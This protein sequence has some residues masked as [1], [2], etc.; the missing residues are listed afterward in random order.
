VVQADARQLPEL[1]GERGIDQ[2]DVIVS[3]LPGWVD[4]ATQEALIDSV[5]P[6]MGADGVFV[7][8]GYRVTSWMPPAR[9]FRQLL[10]G[11]FDEVVIGRTIRRNI[12][13]AFVRRARKIPV[14]RPGPSDP[15]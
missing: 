8:F 12:P 10:R 7:T 9:R 11:V 1:F 6:V 3:G 14:F 15:G 5:C 2:V 4:R 13:P